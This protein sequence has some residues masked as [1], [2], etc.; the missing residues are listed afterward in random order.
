MPEELLERK[1]VLISHVE[2]I[3]HSSSRWIL[4]FTQLHKAMP[5][6]L[7]ELTTVL[8]SHR[9]QSVDWYAYLATKVP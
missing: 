7:L 4:T 2:T 8:I 6:E 9:F 3:F 1:T 5:E